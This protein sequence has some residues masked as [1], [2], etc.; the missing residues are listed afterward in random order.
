MAR[1]RLTYQNWIVDIGRDP[2][3]AFEQSNNPDALLTDGGES[4]GLFPS[5]DKA[6]PPL[7]EELIQKV[8]SALDGLT[9]DEREFIIRFYYM[10]QSYQKISKQTG[11]VAHRLVSLHNR[12][13]NKLKANLS[14]FVRLRFDLE[15]SLKKICPLCE[16]S[17]VEQ[18]NRLIITRDKRQTWRPVLKALKDNYGITVSSPQLLIGHERYHMQSGD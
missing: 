5:V 18:I 17:Q 4:T 15:P 14:G 16:S 9:D 7:E 8:R 12:A 13:I 1:N 11:R 2:G 6:L 3:S 10:G